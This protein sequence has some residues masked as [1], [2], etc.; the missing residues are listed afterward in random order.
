[1]SA[2]SIPVAAGTG[3]RQILPGK[4]P[5]TNVSVFRPAQ[6]E[7]NPSPAGAVMIS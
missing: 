6:F 2:P 4:G 1:M 7:A 5:N 3:A